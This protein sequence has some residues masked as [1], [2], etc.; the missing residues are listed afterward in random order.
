M[1][2]IKPFIPSLLLFFLDFG[3][4]LFFPSFLHFSS[5]VEFRS[6]WNNLGFFP[7]VFSNLLLSSFLRSTIVYLFRVSSLGWSILEWS[8]NAFLTV[9]SN[10]WIVLNAIVFTSIVGALI[11]LDT[12]KEV[13]TIVA[14]TDPLQTGD[15]LSCEN[16]NSYLKWNKS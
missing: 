9:V 5:T 8:I 7:L 1:P 16:C 6:C 11:N 3:S 12:I 15:W 4:A 13:A 10:V 2:F 14:S